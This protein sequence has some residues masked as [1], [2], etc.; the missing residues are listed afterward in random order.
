VENNR[1]K[2][3]KK[4]KKSKESILAFKKE[5][6]AMMLEPIY[7]ENIKDIIT[8]LTSKL[9][10]IAESYGYEIEFPERAK[11]DI[12]GDIYYFVYP[13]K[14]KTRHGFKK[15]NLEVQY[16]IY[17]EGKWMGVITEVK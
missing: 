2:Q 1:S 6:R 4:R 7:G 14:V 8:R 16:M 13:I 5:L 12:E 17:D 10:E 15:I 9:E 11:K 3:Q